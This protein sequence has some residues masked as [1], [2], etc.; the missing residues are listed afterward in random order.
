MGIRRPGWA[1]LS[2]QY[3]GAQ[4]PKLLL[5]TTGLNELSMEGTTLVLSGLFLKEESRELTISSTETFSFM[6]VVIKPRPGGLSHFFRN[7]ETV[8]R[9]LYRLLYQ[10]FNDFFSLILCFYLRK[11]RNFLESIRDDIN[12]FLPLKIWTR[13]SALDNGLD[14]KAEFGFGSLGLRGDG[15][16]GWSNQLGNLEEREV[17]CGE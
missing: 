9:V 15:E 6:Q 11:Y 5:L 13:V 3:V 1:T 10:D 2:T 14:G 17:S 12:K 8:L 4:S 16:H 7:F